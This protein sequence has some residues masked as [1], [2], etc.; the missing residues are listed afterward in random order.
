MSNDQAIVCDDIQPQIAAY[1]LGDHQ[2]EPAVHAHVA[3]CARCQQD[4]GAYMQ[5]TRVLP[6]A[7]PLVEPSPAL[8][9]RILAAATAPAPVVTPPQPLRPQQRSW[10][11]ARRSRLALSFAFAVLLA[12][13]GWNISLQSRLNAQA[14]QITASRETWHTVVAILNSPD[15]RA[16]ALTGTNASGHIWAAE[17]DTVACLVAQGLPDAGA[18]NV[19]QAWLIQNGTAHSGGTFQVRSGTAWVLIHSDEPITSYDAIDVTIEP[20][21]G[22]RTP[23]GPGIL[24]GALTSANAR[25]VQVQAS[26]FPTISDLDH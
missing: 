21:G 2:L 25:S 17:R 4:L 9:S 5:V 18:N 7:E 14:T 10:P 6:Y 23:S 3:A 26:L 15:V 24:Q 19:Y 13:L 22:S 11:R 20:R 8:R 16:F 12:L 1:A